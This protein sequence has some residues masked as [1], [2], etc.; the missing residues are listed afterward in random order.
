MFKLLEAT[1]VPEDNILEEALGYE[2]GAPEWI[3]MYWS[4]L[5]DE[6]IV[7][8]GRVSGD[9]NWESFLLYVQ[10]WDELAAYVHLLGS[11]ETTACAELLINRKERKAY[12]ASLD[13]AYQ[14]V[15]MQWPA[16][17]RFDPAGLDALRERIDN[18]QPPEGQD[19]VQKVKARIEKT[20]KAYARLAAWLEQNRE[21]SHV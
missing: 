17:A 19:L 3:A 18:G 6:C 5:W 21:A 12:L 8:D 14:K 9:H 1:R 16:P 13:V 2:G 15:R 20:N 10:F 11:S 4:P 7:D